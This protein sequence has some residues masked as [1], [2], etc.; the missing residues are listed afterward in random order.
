M[1]L[2]KL[3]D[4]QFQASLTKLTTQDLPLKTA[5]VLRGVVKR[6]DEEIVKYNQ[7]RSAALQNFGE[8]NE[9]N[10][11]KTDEKGNITLNDANAKAL[12]SELN[13]LM[14]TDVDVGSIKMSDLGD[15]VALSTAD[16]LRLDD[17]VVD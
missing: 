2:S 6:C 1:K 16:L 14:T 17:I 8:K 13:N 9:D 5:F 4:P 10:T 11:L 15:K 3:V 7:V 12:M